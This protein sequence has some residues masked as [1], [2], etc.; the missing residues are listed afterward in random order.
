MRRS[1]GSRSSADEEPGSGPFRGREV[2]DGHSGA[3][4]S[5]RGEP[6]A[7][8]AGPAVQALNGRIGAGY[9]WNRIDEDESSFGGIAYETDTHQGFVTGTMT[10]PLGDS[11]G[12]R[13][14]M[15]PNY[16]RTQS[17]GPLDVDAGGIDASADIFWRNPE[18][19]ELGAEATYSWQRG[20]LEVIDDDLT[21]HS[22]RGEL[23]GSYFI[24]PADFWPLDLGASFTYSG[25]DLDEEI[26]DDVQKAWSVGG[27]VRL[28]PLDVLAFSVGGLYRELD[29]HGFADTKTSGA[30]FGLDALVHRTPGLTLSPRFEVGNRDTSTF[31]AS[32]FRQTYYSV[33]ARVT[34]SFPGGDSLVEL[35]RAYY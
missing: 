5:G 11:L 2:C 8:A 15:L 30:V 34:M 14:R 4:R 32:N 23:Y 29:S 6:S 9:E 25:L 19:F 28:Y 33:L 27:A 31:F 10:V 13:L 24:S 22:F 1:K 26:T 18:T 20:H 17:D 35:N 3:A 7:Q 16:G 21:V 12:L